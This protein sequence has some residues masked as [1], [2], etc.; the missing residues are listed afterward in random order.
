MIIARGRWAVATKSESEPRAPRHLPKTATMVPSHPPQTDGKPAPR[1]DGDH[2]DSN[3][4]PVDMLVVVVHHDG[5]VRAVAACSKLRSPLMQAVQQKPTFIG[6]PVYTW[7]QAGRKLG[8]SA[9]YVQRLVKAGKGAPTV[10]VGDYGSRR[11]FTRRD[12]EVP[13]SHAA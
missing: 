10:P 12:E 8:C 3:L 1:V 6:G 2:N 5:H 13:A 11:L 9:S 4:T 7:E